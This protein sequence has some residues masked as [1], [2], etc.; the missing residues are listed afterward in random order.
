MSQTLSVSSY[1]PDTIRLPSPITAIAVIKSVCPDRV[2]TSL[3]LSRS[4]TFSV[5]SYDPET[6]RRP[7]GVNATARTD[8]EFTSHVCSRGPPEGTRLGAKGRS[9]VWPLHS[10]ACCKILAISG[11]GGVHITANLEHAR[12]VGA[13]LTLAKPCEPDQIR[14]AVRSLEQGPG[15]T[16]D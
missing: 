2:R 11:R 7:S 10:R 14:N 4:H 12:R 8:P 9:Q 16:E 5:L 1:E 6:A 13:D 15:K 3:P